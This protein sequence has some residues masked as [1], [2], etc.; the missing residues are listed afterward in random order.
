M[1][2]AIF[3]SSRSEKIKTSEATYKNFAEHLNCTFSTYDIKTCIR[4][5]HFIAQCFHETGGFVDNSEKGG[6]DTYRGGIY[7]KGRGLIHI[8]HDDNYL[9]YYDSTNVIKYFYL[10]QGYKKHNPVEGVTKYIERKSE[11]WV[12]F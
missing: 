12:S 1:D 4:K 11:S 5:I 10:Y 8:T 6:K 3:K 9:K 7:F 2:D